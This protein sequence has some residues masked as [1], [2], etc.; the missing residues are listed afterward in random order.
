LVGVQLI[1]AD[2]VD[3]DYVKTGVRREGL[4]RGMLGFVYRLPPAFVAL[5]MG[6]LLEL[7]GYNANLPPANQPIQ[8]AMS[9]RY[10]IGLTPF[11]VS[12][13]VAGLVYVYPLYGER[14]QQIRVGVQRRNAELEES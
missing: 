1:F 7:S 12:L 14:L 3:E 4:Y 10:I 8:V 9:I 11:F 6:E 5:G 2:T 13:I